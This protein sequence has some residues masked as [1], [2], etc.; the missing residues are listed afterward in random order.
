M[1]TPE[2][3]RAS[4]DFAA[5]RKG[6]RFDAGRFLLQVVDRREPEPGEARLGFTITRKIGTAVERNRIRRRLRA[7]VREAGDAFR[8]G[9]DY[10]VV[11]RREVLS[12]DFAALAQS[13][14]RATS[15]VHA[16]GAKRQGETR[17]SPAPTTH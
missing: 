16:R 12:E 6:R 10:V 8:R 11:A 4:R 7:A 3:L 17:L 5:A 2:R 14:S 1:P 9:H 15:H 13:L